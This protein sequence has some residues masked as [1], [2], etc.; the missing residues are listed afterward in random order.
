MHL[1]SEQHFSSDAGCCKAVQLTEQS[2]CRPL[3]SQ[4]FVPLFA[5]SQFGTCSFLMLLPLP[6]IAHLWNE[7]NDNL[8][9]KLLCS[10]YW[11]IMDLKYLYFSKEW[12]CSFTLFVKFFVF[13][14]LKK[15]NNAFWAVINVFDFFLY[16]VLIPVSMPPVIW[17]KFVGKYIYF[18]NFSWLQKP[19]KKN[20]FFHFEMIVMEV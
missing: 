5:S 17:L 3:K 15:E 8:Q 18:H 9:K 12:D 7:A 20:F 19:W 1:P 11:Y 16:L 2:W 6:W 13:C 4:L 10:H 14:F